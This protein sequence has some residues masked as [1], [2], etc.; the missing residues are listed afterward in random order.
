MRS[1]ATR[2]LALALVAATV[3]LAG[4]QSP[5]PG[6]RRPRLA[7]VGTIDNHGGG[8]SSTPVLVT[9]TAPAIGASFLSVIDTTTLSGVASCPNGCSSVTWVNSRGGSG[10][11]TGTATWAINGGTAA[12]TRLDDAFVETTT[13]TLQ[14]HT[15]SPIGGSVWQ[16]VYDSSGGTYTG[17]VY[18]SGDYAYPPTN[19]NS[20]TNE[21]LFRGVPSV[22]VTATNYDIIGT[23]DSTYAPS[24]TSL[25]SLIFGMRAGA[26]GATNFCGFG[27]KGS[28]ATPDLF[29]YE[30]NG[31]AL[32]LKASA[33]AGSNSGAV[34][35]KLSVRGNT[36]T[37]Y[38]SGNQVLTTTSTF[39]SAGGNNGGG[40]SFGT[41]GAA[42]PGQIATG[43]RWER[44]QIIDQDATVGGVQLQTGSNLITVTATDVSGATGSSTINVIYGTLDTVNPSISITGPTSSPTH[45]TSLTS[46]VISG[47]ATD[48]TAVSSV[49]CTYNGTPFSVVLTGGGTTAA[50]FSSTATL[51]SGPHDVV[52]TVTDAAGNTASDTLTVTQSTS[53]ITAPTVTFTAPATGS[54]ASYTSSTSSLNFAGTGSDAV[55]VTSGTV[56]CNNSSASSLVLGTGI[57]ASWSFSIASLTSGLMTTC[58]VTLKDAQNNAGT[59]TIAVAYNLPVAITTTNLANATRTVAYSASLLA[60][61]GTAPYAWSILSGTLPTG[62]TLSG[63]TGGISG[64]PTVAGTATI[65]FRVTDSTLPSPVTA[66]A[67]LTLTVIDPGAEGP[68][69]FFEEYRNRSECI[70]ALSFRPLAS[71]ATSPQYNCAHPHY[72]N[73][74][75]PSG[76]PTFGY[77]GGS[78]PSNVDIKQVDYVWLSGDSDDHAQDA[79]K[80]RID[81]W[82]RA[83][84]LASNIDAVT[85]TI[86]I[87]VGSVTITNG[88]I[89][90]NAQYKLDNEIMTVTAI[91]AAA[92][93]LTVVRGQY[94]TTAASHTAGATGRGSKNTLHANYRMFLPVGEASWAN[95]HSYV[96]VWDEFKTDSWIYNGLDGMKTFN[97]RRAGGIHI[98]PNHV[99]ASSYPYGGTLDHATE[100]FVVNVRSYAGCPNDSNQ[101]GCGG[102]DLDSQ[103][104]GGQIRNNY[105]VPGDGRIVASKSPLRVMDSNLAPVGTGYPDNLL[106]WPQRFTV[107]PN[108]WVRYVARLVLNANDYDYFSLWCIDEFD[109]TTTI[110]LDIPL[111]EGSEPSSI[112]QFQLEYDSSRNP[113]ALRNGTYTQEWVSYFRDFIV[114]KDLSN[115][116]LTTLL[117]RKPKR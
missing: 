45:S 52:C 94:S 32:T 85:T 54:S 15:A 43:S 111:G 72:K 110:M 41:P 109:G 17:K 69:A 92:Y 67:T 1:R 30:V 38:R 63:S 116:D 61:Q 89:N 75:L 31:G 86:P 6:P 49:A 50:T 95:G 98:E 8:P 114:L 57:A 77:R 37:A 78:D 23:T 48:N 73:Q 56:T 20:A 25:T 81:A 103:T 82:I 29:L 39:C 88:A 3:A 100:L 12:A 35:Y 21:L 55:G 40:L 33:N 115:A 42:V 117:T 46:L 108:R 47:P 18:Y 96:T 107:K 14:T 60:T 113:I 91:N 28:S 58:T 80:I 104:N 83:G 44:F 102:N 97:F 101:T 93:T 105:V 2:A 65:H 26:S 16:L 4:A 10:T 68:H 24:S 99:Y 66:D 74:L 112:N 34:D 76:N 22:A 79:T 51:T 11:A 27:I 87:V 5:T 71:E 84:T 9:I 19:D 59:A 62:L 53:D 64:T 36:I 70:Q 106:V 7:R 90:V 13:K